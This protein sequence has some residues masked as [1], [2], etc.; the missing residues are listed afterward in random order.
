MAGPYATV[1]LSDNVFLQGR[2]AWGRS[3][4]EVSP[5]MTYADEFQSERW[6]VSSTLTGRWRYGPWQLRPS[7]SLTYMEDVAKSYT[8]S[9]GVVIPEVKAK[10]GQARAG[11]A[12]SYS[13]LLSDG[14]IEPR[15]G[16]DVIWN[17]AA[18]NA[19]VSVSGVP[20]GPEG[21]RGRAEIGMRA[22]ASSGLSL[23]VSGS[24][25]GIGAKGF[26]AIIGKAT[27]RVPLN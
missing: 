22:T 14:I 27:V 12:I 4:N 5:Y 18:D 19:P 21:V 7:A 10:L 17:F 23:D 26:D 11:P 25:D 2:A 9:L 13:Y 6:L 20:T 16:L 15:V 8:D 3:S 24:Y 1:R